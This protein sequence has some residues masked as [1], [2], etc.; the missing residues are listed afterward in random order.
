MLMISSPVPSSDAL[1]HQS[2]ALLDIW[3]KFNHLFSDQ[4]GSPILAN[5]VPSIAMLS[6]AI[7][8]AQVAW[9]KKQDTSFGVAKGHFLNFAETIN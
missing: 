5:S 2:R 9:R 1:E 7:Q 6:E 8:E 3:T 4:R